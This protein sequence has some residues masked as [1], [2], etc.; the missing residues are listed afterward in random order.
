MF[1]EEEVPRRV[2]IPGRWRSQCSVPHPMRGATPQATF[3]PRLGSPSPGTLPIPSLTR[4]PRPHPFLR[5]NHSRRLPAVEASAGSAE[6]GAV[7]ASLGGPSVRPSGVRPSVSRSGGAVGLSVYPSWAVLLPG[8]S[9]LRASHPRGVCLSSWLYVRT[10][11]AVGVSVH[12]PRCPFIGLSLCPWESLPTHRCPSVR[13]DACPSSGFCLPTGVSIYLM[14]CPCVRWGVCLS[15]WVSVYQGV[16]LCFRVSV[17]T[18]VC[19]S[20]Y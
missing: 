4:H 5:L 9:V 11:L 10:P 7:G 20:G 2:G 14:W 18:S 17:G 6:P 3:S 16:Y 13:R 19:P 1:H 8:L 15:F 12:F